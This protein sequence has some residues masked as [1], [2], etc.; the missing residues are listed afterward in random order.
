MQQLVLGSTSPYRRQLL[1]KLGL[2]FATAAPDIDETPLPGESP[3]GLV[4]R[5]A[6]AKAQDVSKDYPTGL[7]VGSDQAAVL[8]GR[9]IGKPADHAAAVR[10]LRTASGQA[11][12]FLTGL[13]LYNA[14]TGRSQVTVE[15]YA[16]QFRVLDD[17]QITRY[18]AKERPY[19]CAGSFKSEGFGITLFRALEGRD[20]NTLIGLPLIALV[21]MLGN[22][23]IHLP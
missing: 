8:D 18:L 10:Q 21:E 4:R 3:E 7:I 2:D 16:V 6:E 19:D 9:I 14:T 11:V 15:P 17:E 22:E 23:G 13:C 20:P 12:R 5:L 1:A